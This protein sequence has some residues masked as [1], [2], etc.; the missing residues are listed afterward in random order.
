MIGMTQNERYHWTV[1]YSVQMLFFALCLLW[2]EPLIASEADFNRFRAMDPGAVAQE[3]IR[4]YRTDQNLIEL[5]NQ[6]RS[7]FVD[8]I[9]PT[10]FERLLLETAESSQ[11]G[12][13]VTKLTRK[14]GVRSSSVYQL[15]PSSDARCVPAQKSHQCQPAIVSLL[16][17]A[18]HGQSFRDIMIEKDEACRCLLFEEISVFG[19]GYRRVDQIPASYCQ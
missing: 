11:T 3:L 8:G 18:A 16:F 4:T 19:K 5:T 9:E 17:S 10:F 14:E 12:C 7:L 13:V 15:V 6:N 1:S 2:I